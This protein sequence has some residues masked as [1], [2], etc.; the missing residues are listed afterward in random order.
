MVCF[1]LPFFLNC[2][3][4]SLPLFLYLSWEHSSVF[5]FLL[6]FSGNGK[7]IMKLRPNNGPT[8]GLAVPSIQNAKTYWKS[9]ACST[10][11]NA[12]RGLN[13]FWFTVQDWRAVPS[14]AVLGEEGEVLF[15]MSCP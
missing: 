14:F 15:D 10:F 5:S 8:K 13:T 12:G 11:A 9:V 6:R 3:P 2:R 4:C 7:L 1:F